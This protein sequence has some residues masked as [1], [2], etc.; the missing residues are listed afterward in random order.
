VIRYDARTRQKIVTLRTKGY[1]YTEICEALGQHI[2]KGSLSF[3]CRDVV[4]GAQQQERITQIK[5]DN[6]VMSRE[7]AVVTNKRILAEKIAG[8][9]A[10]NQDIHPLLGDR[11]A[12]LIALA[13]LYLGEGAKWR[14]RRGLM[15]GSSDPRIIQLYIG[16]LR[17]CYDIH[18]DQLKGRIQHRADQDPDALLDFWSN[19]SGIRKSNFYPCYIDKRTIGQISR[20]PDYK[21][22]CAVTCAGT[23]VQLELEQITDII[24]GAV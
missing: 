15:L 4:L 1:T 12:R 18:L 23:H 16:L 3:I 22:V 24:C 21:G 11:R 10:A 19:I 6:L 8:Y 9:R 14:G 2:P 7:K 13:M 20:H 17:D 5:R